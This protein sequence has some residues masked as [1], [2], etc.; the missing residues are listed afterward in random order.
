MLLDVA[1]SAVA[2][3]CLT[4]SE[5][6]GLSSSFYIC[7]LDDSLPGTL[8]LS[9]PVQSVGPPALPCLQHSVVTLKCGDGFESI[10]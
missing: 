3:R 5:D 6:P 2:D 4:Q 10:L 9:L 8:S 7:S 1:C